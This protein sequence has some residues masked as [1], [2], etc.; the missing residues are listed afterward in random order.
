MRVLNPVFL[1]ELNPRLRCPGIRGK[2]LARGHR[3]I[4]VIEPQH[5]QAGAG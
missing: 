3:G 4:D 5:N 1:N 2:A